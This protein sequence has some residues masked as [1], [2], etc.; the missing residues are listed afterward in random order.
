ML[1]KPHHKRAAR[2]FLVGMTPVEVA[3]RLQAFTV[4]QVK[5]WRM[6]LDFKTYMMRLERQYLDLLDKDIEHIRRSATVR[7]QEIVET[8]YHSPRFNM[9]HFEWAVNKVFQLTTLREKVNR[10]YVHAEL[11]EGK[12]VATPEQKAALKQLVKVSSD[13]ERYT[14]SMKQGEA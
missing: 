6:D 12:P 8:P 3:D 13:A 9:G 10:E 7:L 14:T 5:H 2:Y 11:S 4:K 1:L